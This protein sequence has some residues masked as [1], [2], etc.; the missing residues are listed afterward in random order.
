MIIEDLDYHVFLR[1][2][3]TFSDAGLDH[4]DPGDP[5]L[6]E[7]QRIMELNKQ[8]F[9]FGDGILLDMCFVSMGVVGFYGFDPETVT[10]GKCLTTTHPDDLDRRILVRSKLLNI[11]NILYSKKTGIGIISTNFRCRTRLGD[12]ANI[13][14][15]AFLFYSEL[16]Y[17]S[18]FIIMVQTDISDF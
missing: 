16:P 7:V 9:C 5:L 8:F 11:A 14:H 18:V 4:I 12:Y 13:L 3:D 15:Q 2:F 1:I 6:I 17:E 10:F